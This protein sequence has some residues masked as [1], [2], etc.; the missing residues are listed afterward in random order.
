[1]SLFKEDTLAFEPKLSLTEFGLP[2][3]IEIEPIH[4]CNL[5]CTMCHVSYENLTYQKIDIELLTKHLKGLEGRWSIVGSTHEPTA[6]PNFDDLVLALS[7]LGMHIELTTNGTLLNKSLVERIA[8]CNF[9]KVNISF[10]G[11]RK[12]TYESIRRNANY[13]RAIESILN[14]KN[15]V[16]NQDAY[17]MISNTLMKSNL[18]E[19]IEAVDFWEEND[20]DKLNFII[21]VIREMDKVLV[22]ESLQDIMPDVYKKLDEAAQYVIDREYRLVLS[23]S[24][25]NCHSELKK[26]YPN[27]FVV[28][29]VRSNNPKARTNIEPR[30]YL[31]NGFFPGL[32]VKCRSPF[33]FARILYNGDV[34]LCYQFTIGNIYEK[35]FVDI[36]Y[37]ERAEQVR[38]ALRR[39]S[40]NCEACDYY[41]FAIKA[42]Y[43]SYKEDEKN[44]Y[45]A[46]LLSRKEIK[47]KP[48]FV[49]NCDGYNI[50]T[51]MGDYYGLPKELGEVDIRIDDLSALEGV[52]INSSLERLKLLV[53]QTQLQKANAEIALLQPEHPHP[54]F[55][56][57]FGSYNIVAW[58]NSYFGVPKQL[59]SV[60]VASEDVYRLEGIITDISITRLKKV[61]QNHLELSIQLQQVQTQLQ[62]TQAQFQETQT[63]L[64]QTQT[65]FQETQTQLQETQTRIEAMESSKFWKLR[66]A[67]FKVK[68]RLGLPADES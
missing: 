20:F 47:R 21:M 14:F 22:G 34:Q 57:E 23:S 16:I 53:F 29:N 46:E 61:L 6:H 38:T 32:H 44:F 58:K 3:I 39:S 52:L 56:E 2:E 5:R 55:L 36:W 10:D 65:Q 54:I 62:Q 15:S 4:T 40:K 43:V 1:M 18:D 9:E 45:N 63:Q 66:R 8:K 27:N 19:V 67:W 11:I 68:K 30:S 7:D 49:E 37:G 28:D 33:K 17:F 41:R 13:E 12:N 60:D 42:P 50:V 48:E 26:I 24:I 31:Q 64:Q 35:P 51:W 25:F 59:G